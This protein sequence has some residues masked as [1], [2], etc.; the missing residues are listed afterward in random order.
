MNE[1]T[2]EYLIAKADL[3]YK[4]AQKQMER[5]EV[6]EAIRNIERANSAMARIFHLEE[7]E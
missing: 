4:T 1:P 2:I 7:R 3:C 5:E 6:A